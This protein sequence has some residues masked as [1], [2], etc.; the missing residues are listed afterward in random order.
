MKGP[1]LDIGVRACP[2]Q[3]KGLAIVRLLLGNE[4]GIRRGRCHDEVRTLGGY[5]GGVRIGIGGVTVN[6]NR[7]FYNAS[8]SVD[9]TRI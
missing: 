3:N 1:F 6:P 8:V 4:D 5:G 7:M 9:A 2:Y